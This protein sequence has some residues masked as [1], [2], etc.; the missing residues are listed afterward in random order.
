MSNHSPLSNDSVTRSGP[1]TESRRDRLPRRL[2]RS[3][4]QPV[5]FLGFWSAIAL[6]FVHI[7][8]LLQGLDGPH[9]TAAFLTLLAVNLFALYVGH[10]YNQS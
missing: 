1:E 6:P 10:D 3:L 7:P 9:V 5:Q 8:L 4:K 2:P